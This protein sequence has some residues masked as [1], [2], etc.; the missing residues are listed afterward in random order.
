MEYLENLKQ[1]L[2]E[3]VNQLLETLSS[4]LPN[5]L[6]AAT[7]ILTGLVLAA[8]ARWTIVRLSA[9][10]D[11]M[12][13]VVGF[14]SVP[15]L[16]NWPIGVILGWLV[17]WLI[18]LFFST[19]AA[20]TLGLEGLANWLRNFINNIPVYLIAVISIIAGVW[21]G[22]YVNTKIQ[23]TSRESGQHQVEILGQT[24][25][26]VIISFAVISALSQVGLDVSL[27]ETM[28]VILV[29]AV[30]G[31]IALAF[32]LGAGPT[33]ANVISGRYVRK[34]YQ[35]GQRVCIDEIEGEILEL[36]PTGVVLDTKSGRTFIPAKLFGETA[37]VLLDNEETHAD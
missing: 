35:V 9:G 5:L 19:A 1:L 34:T 11:R 3:S 16:R 25:R 31:G 28:M 4:Y 36:L 24:L 7:L 6:G 33:L 8:L 23:S 30:L 27:F 15:L 29:T 12:V 26:I 14:T 18:I 32:G 10:L 21:I 2:L 20:E 13:H 22:N 17:F 37:S